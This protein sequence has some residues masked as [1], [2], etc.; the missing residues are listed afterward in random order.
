MSK[1]REL[2]C[3][4]C[5]KQFY[6]ANWDIARG[7]KYCSHRCS[8]IGSGS[9][10]TGEGYVKILL[11]N[12]PRADKSGFVYEHIVVMERHLGRV[13]AKGEIVHHTDHDR[14]N[15]DITNLELIESQAKH[16]RIHRVWEY[17]G[18]RGKDRI[19]A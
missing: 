16:F 4:A 9:Y 18:K 10:I 11:K 7:R 3:R 17:E 13:I 1:G 6:A 14:S 5:S 15:N 8:E 12:H 19:K 2:E